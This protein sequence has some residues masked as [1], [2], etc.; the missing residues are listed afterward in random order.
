MVDGMSLYLDL[1]EK[2][3][4]DTIYDPTGERGEGRDWPS[5]A[6]TMVG[7]A[8]L[9]S[10]RMLVEDVVEAGV[11]GDLVETGVWRGGACIMMRAALKSL[12][13]IDRRVWV[14]DSFQGLPRP[15]PKYPVDAG[16]MHHTIDLLSVSL[17]AVK[18]NFEAYGLLDAQV[19]FLEGF[20]SEVL[21]GPIGTIAVLR[22][23]GDMYGSTMDA[24]VAL[25]DR[26]SPGGYLVVDDY[27]LPGCHAAI[28]DFRAARGITAEMVAID[29][30]GFYWKV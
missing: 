29:W 11:P 20:F 16:D 25:Y 1:M 22:L 28:D 2:V 7:R 4:T 17:S 13:V 3:L 19:E 12:N 8:R 21:P 23:D 5:R 14:V 15:D 9:H 18:S 26:I 10:L 24:L 6:H 27:A 30:T